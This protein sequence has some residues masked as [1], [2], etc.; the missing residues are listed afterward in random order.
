MIEGNVQAIFKKEPN[1]YNQRNEVRVEV[2]RPSFIL[3]KY[4]RSMQRIFLKDVRNCSDTG[5]WSVRTTFRA[6]R[7]VVSS[8]LRKS[9]EMISVP[10][11]ITETFLSVMQKTLSQF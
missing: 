7:K 10:Q 8:T 11:K 4:F 9:R 1:Q 2:Y 5:D 6:A 3:H